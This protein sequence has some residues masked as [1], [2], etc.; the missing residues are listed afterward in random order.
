MNS[1]ADVAVSDHDA[2]V[3]VE[4]AGEIDLT[5]ARQISTTILSAARADATTVVVDLTQVAYLDSAGIRLLYRSATALADRR[6][7]LVLVVPPESRLRNLL[8]MTGVLEAM[9]VVSDAA[10]GLAS[11]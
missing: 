1:L 10:S 11:P 4:V 2:S 6:Q 3:L 8:E 7:L 9:T 5:N